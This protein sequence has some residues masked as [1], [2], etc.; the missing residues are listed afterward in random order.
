MISRSRSRTWGRAH[1]DKYKTETLCSYPPCTTAAR[2]RGLCQKHYDLARR[3][4]PP[5]CSADA[6]SAA[7]AS[8]GLC[9]HHYLGWRKEHTL[10]ACSIDGCDNHAVEVKLCSTHYNRLRRTGTTAERQRGGEVNIRHPLYLTWGSMKG[11]CF[12][13]NTPYHKDYGGRGITVCEPWLTFREFAADIDRLRGER[14][15]GMTLDRIDNDGNYEPGNVRWATESEQRRNQ[16][17]RAT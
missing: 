17:K 12:C 8:R 10:P 14:P 9:N 15:A 5:T 11:R 16:R 3:A 7:A 6:C 13:E 1:L 2:K 4:N